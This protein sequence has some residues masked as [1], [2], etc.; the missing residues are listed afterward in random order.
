MQASVVASTGERDRRRHWLCRE[1]V[2]AILRVPWPVRAKAVENTTR[3]LMRHA[4]ALAGRHVLVVGADDPSLC[5]LPVASVTLH[6]DD[7]S[8]PAVDAALLPTV[9]EPCDLVVVILPKSREQLAFWLA[10]VRGQLNTKTEV[11]LVGAANG[12]VRGGVTTLETLADEA[13]SQFDSARHCKLF[14]ST[15]SPAPFVLAEHE[16]VWSLDGLAIVSYPGVFSHGRLDAGSALLLDTLPAAGLAGAVLDVGCGAGVLSAV[17][18]QRGAR[19][20]AVDVSA[21]AVAATQQTLQR[22]GLDGA[23]R[24]SDLY[25][26]VD[27]TFDVIVTN[28]P[29]HDGTR[30]TT[31]ITRRL[32]AEAPARLRAQGELWLVANQGLPYGDWLR[33]AFAAVEVAAENRH[34]RVWRAWR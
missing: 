6:G 30:R 27:G 8:V 16:Q 22:N 15:L 3:L 29:F 26:A 10:A 13:A 14:S 17:L 20:T 28:P 7:A 19:V 32:I 4:D 33:E 9:P 23:V 12:G 18:A 24:L 25:A 1:R 31:D 34:F 21:A 5:Q 2:N 11:W